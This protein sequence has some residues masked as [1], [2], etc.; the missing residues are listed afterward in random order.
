MLRLTGVEKTFPVSG[1]RVRALRGVDLEIASGGLTAIL[2]ASG[3]GKSTL[4]RVV[5]GFERPERG[6]VTLDSHTLVGPG[7]FVRPERRGIG[8]VPQDGALFPHVDVA[9][10]VGFGLRSRTH[11]DLR[12]GTRRRRARAERVSELLEMVGLAGYE[13]RRPD[14]LSGGQ[15]QRVALARAL[16]PSPG[17]VLLDEPFSAIDAALRS[18]LGMEVRDLLRRLHTTAVLVTHDQQEALSLADAVAVMRDGRVVQVG[19]PA[20]VY[21]HPVDAFTADFVGDAVILDGRVVAHD[22]GICTVD[23][24]LGQVTASTSEL[25]QP[26]TRCAVLV[27][28][29]NLALGEGTVPAR[30]RTTGYFGHELLVTLRLGP[31]GDGPEVRLRTTNTKIPEPDSPTFVRILGPA[32]I[33][34]EV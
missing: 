8:I 31:D 24:P 22:H 32:H 27:R 7:V 6:E 5:A 34:P 4:L 17:V 12:L 25:H 2:G 28:P 20:D 13:R 14:E 1:S 30:V 26:G 19:S 18:E 11:P 33:L 16:A 21:D 29:E 23:C 9:G 3:C 10:N 15:Q